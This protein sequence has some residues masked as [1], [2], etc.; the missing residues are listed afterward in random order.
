MKFSVIVPVFNAA[1]TLPR[2]MDS[3]ID[4]ASD[5]E[6]LLVDDGSSD[7]SHDLCDAYADR[8]PFVRAFHQQNAGPSAARN[9]GLTAA[10]G[11][12]VMFSD[13]D[14][15]WEPGTLAALEKALPADLLIFGVFDDIFEGGRLVASRA[16]GLE[17]RGYAGP[18]ELLLDFH[19]LLGNNLLYSQCTKVYRREL[20]ADL[21]FDETLSM[22]EDITF[23][24]GYIPRIASARVVE[25]SFYHYVH[26]TAGGSVSSS[27][28]PGYYENVRR[29]QEGQIAL[30]KRY[31]AYTAENELALRNF[32]L[33]RVSAAVQNELAAPASRGE[34]Y[35]RA[36]AI[37]LSPEAADAAQGAPENRFHR[38]LAGLIRRRQALLGCAMFGLL[39]FM[40]KHAAGFIA[41]RKGN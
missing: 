28:Y 38:I 35:R 25:G 39:K 1:A 10:A 23:N 26:E 12:Y 21:R 27:H 41:R 6:I 14:D 34:R 15:F 20:L 9:V 18:R 31:D 2:L 29:V 33:G 17:A 16:W 40:K 5:A 19:A 37:L 3:L 4:Q 22:G 36:K 13:A 8:Y 32:F 11:E 24:L 7:A 30:L